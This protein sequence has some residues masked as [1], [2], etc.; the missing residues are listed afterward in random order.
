MPFHT[1]NRAEFQNGDTFPGETR[2]WKIA[3]S[4]NGF[5]EQGW[6]LQEA[7]PISDRLQWS[8]WDRNPIS[9]CT[10]MPSHLHTHTRTQ[11]QIECN[12]SARFGVQGHI[13]Y[14]KKRGPSVR[15]ISAKVSGNNFTRSFFFSLNVIFNLCVRGLRPRTSGFR[16]NETKLNET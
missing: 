9:P 3:E 1:D 7:R 13:R 11:T 5:N 8:C 12:I 6:W 15:N 14:Q 4:F 2:V 10:E 16:F